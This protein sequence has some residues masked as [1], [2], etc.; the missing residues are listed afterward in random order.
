MN[1]KQS[2]NKQNARLHDIHGPCILHGLKPSPY[3]AEQTKYTG[4]VHD[5]PTTRHTTHA[6]DIPRPQ[7]ENP[8]SFRPGHFEPQTQPWRHPTLVSAGE[9][10][11]QQ[12]EPGQAVAEKS[13]CFLTS[14]QHTF[15]YARQLDWF[16]FLDGHHDL[17]PH[18]AAHHRV[19]AVI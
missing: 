4:I 14:P 12:Q 2:K 5:L 8:S 16:Q 15:G 11:L 1:R 19:C 17:I 9:Q 3:R 7:A 6:H 10:Q 13:Q 18:I